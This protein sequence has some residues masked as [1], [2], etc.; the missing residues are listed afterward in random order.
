LHGFC[1]KAKGDLKSITSE[2]TRKD[3]LFLPIAGIASRDDKL[4]GIDPDIF[5]RCVESAGIEAFIS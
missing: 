4:T 3:I 2:K 1:Y 5:R